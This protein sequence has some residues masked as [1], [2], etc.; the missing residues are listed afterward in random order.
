MNGATRQD[1][2]TN[3]RR[4]IEEA[5]DGLFSA[6]RAKMRQQADYLRMMGESI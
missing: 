4:T 2:Y 1:P 3:N 6:F 5:A